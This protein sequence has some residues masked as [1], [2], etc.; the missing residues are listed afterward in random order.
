MRVFNGKWYFPLPLVIHWPGIMTL[1]IRKVSGPI[2]REYAFWGV[3]I[4]GSEDEV[5]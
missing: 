3:D 4:T 1:L 5:T 2:K